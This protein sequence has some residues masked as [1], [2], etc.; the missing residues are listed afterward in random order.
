MKVYLLNGSPPLRGV[1][2]IREGRCM[3]K[4]SSWSAIWP[5]VS[6]ALLAS[7][8][9]KKSEVRLVDCNVES[10]KKDDLIYDIS[11][12]NPDVLI[13]N[14]GFPSIR[15]DMHIVADIKKT[16]PKIL[17]IGIGVYFTLLEKQSIINYPQIDFACVGEPEFTA[18]ELIDIIETGENDFSRV[19]GLIYREGNRL[20]YNGHRNYIE[21]LDVLPYPARDLLKNDRYTLPHNGHPFTL[22]NFCRGCPY[23]CT[24][25]IAPAYYGRKY[26]RHSIEYILGEIKDCIKNYN[27]RDFLFWGEAFTIDKKFCDTVCNRII[28]ERLP[29]AWSTTTRADTID[30]DMLLKMKQANCQLLGIGIESASQ[31]ILDRAKK[32]EKVEDLKR[33]VS[34][35]K[36]VGIRTMGHFIFGLPGE[37]HQSAESTIRFIK[38]LR[39]D[40]I[41]CY[42][43]VPYPKTE[44]W[45]YAKKHNLIESFNWQNYDFGGHSILRTET[46][47]TEDIDYYRVKAFKSFYLR[48]SFL[49]KQLLI[50]KPWQLFKPIEFF[51]WIKMK[52]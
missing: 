52:K 48:P 28:E 39:L 14:T 6:L 2:Y 32:Q 21:N 13:I 43:A 31:E 19:K 44:L 7:I 10:F 8:I 18:K 46:L 20:V 47:S 16:N 27:I 38:E 37:T 9:R 30:E 11:T 29:I 26:R 23:P 35:C 42:N 22:I 3:Q 41:Q 12:F 51:D 49:L 36:K 1:K 5:P 50:V 24:F 45:E 17:T 25:C 4:T 15:E 33:A 40:Y 34:L